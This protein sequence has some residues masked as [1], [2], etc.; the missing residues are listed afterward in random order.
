MGI[1]ESMELIFIHKGRNINSSY[2]LCFKDI[3][4]K[5]NER[6]EKMITI[7]KYLSNSLQLMFIFAF[8]VMNFLTFNVY[9]GQSSVLAQDEKGN[10]LI[11]TEEDFHNFINMVETSDDQLKGK[12][13]IL[14]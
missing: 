13:I 11:K 5:H 7:K 8:I 1:P 14:N 2:P 12:K 9:G 3:F 10:Y 6:Q 4:L